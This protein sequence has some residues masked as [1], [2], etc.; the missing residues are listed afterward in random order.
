MQ[1]AQFRS[2]TD[3]PDEVILAEHPRPVALHA[4]E[5]DPFTGSQVADRNAADLHGERI[6]NDMREF[7]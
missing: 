6:A 7:Q 1:A 5:P 3:E 4:P 2:A